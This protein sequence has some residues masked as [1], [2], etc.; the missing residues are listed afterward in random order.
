MFQKTHLMLKNQ[1]YPQ[2]QLSHSNQ[3]FQMI[4]INLIDRQYQQNLYYQMN[5]KFLKFYS[6]H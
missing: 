3:K 1:Y 5:P 2:Y 4:L 6:I